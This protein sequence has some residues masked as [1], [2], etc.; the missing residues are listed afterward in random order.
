MQK[1]NANNKNVKP[2]THMAWT[3]NFSA[4]TW[5]LHSTLYSTMN[6]L[7]KIHY[8]LLRL[9]TCQLDQTDKLSLDVLDAREKGTL[10][11]NQ[12]SWAPH[13]LTTGYLQPWETEAQRTS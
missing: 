4:S 13:I 1:Q 8:D 10:S 9:P 7:Q 2:H 6:S 12:L 3:Q 5:V 11:E